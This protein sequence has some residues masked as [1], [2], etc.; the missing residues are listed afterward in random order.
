MDSRNSGRELLD[1]LASLW[2]LERNPEDLVPIVQRMEP[3]LRACIHDALNVLMWSTPEFFETVARA[4]LPLERSIRERGLP[5]LTPS[6]VHHVNRVSYRVAYCLRL[7]PLP[8]EASVR[9]FVPW[10]RQTAAQSGPTLVSCT[11]EWLR[12]FADPILGM[13]YGARGPASELATIELVADVTVAEAHLQFG[14]LKDDR[15]GDLSP[16]DAE[17]LVSDFPVPDALAAL[18]KELAS[19]HRGTLGRARAAYQWILDHVVAGWCDLGRPSSLEYALSDGLCSDQ[20][21]AEL[22]VGLCR[23]MGIAARPRSE[24]SSIR[25]TN[26]A[27][28]S[29]GGWVR[30]DF[31]TTGRSSF[32]PTLDGFLSIRSLR[33]AG[34][35]A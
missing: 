15:A 21:A 4:R 10:L 23:G 5:V 34:E 32:C 27:D 14:D 3:G 1:V 6:D 19:E 25:Q 35:G 18:A 29:H 7:P 2:P 17:W 28:S 11:P 9:L 22:F 13:L 33:S 12:P 20:T 16:M 30:S 8:P 26:E 31:C 24:S